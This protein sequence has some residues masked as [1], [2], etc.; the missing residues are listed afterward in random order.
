MGD[1]CQ[2]LIYGVIFHPEGDGQV[3]YRLAWPSYRITKI[4][5]REKNAK[6]E[7]NA[8]NQVNNSLL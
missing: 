6:Y 2:V 7:K 3:I 8:K 5:S 4:E 1:R